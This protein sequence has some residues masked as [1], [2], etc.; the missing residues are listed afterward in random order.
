MYAPSSLVAYKAKGGKLVWTVGET[1]NETDPTYRLV[2]SRPPVV[3]AGL[4]IVEEAGGRT[5]DRRGGPVPRSGREVVATN[6]AIHEQLMAA[7][8]PPRD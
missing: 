2:F 5:T 3:A 4:L 1:E 6:G 7:L 8:E